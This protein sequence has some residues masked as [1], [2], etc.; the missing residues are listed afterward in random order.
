MDLTWIPIEIAELRD[1][2]AA[3]DAEIE[4]LRGM[5]DG[6]DFVYWRGKRWSVASHRDSG[7]VLASI[8]PKQEIYMTLHRI[9]EE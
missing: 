8:P 2:L 4:R 3:K 5:L 1:A 7:R 9:L 6:E